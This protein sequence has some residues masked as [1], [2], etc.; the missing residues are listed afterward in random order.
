MSQLKVNAI[1]NTSATSDSITLASDGTATAKIT[2]NLSNRNLIINGAM[3]FAQRGTSSTAQ[4]LK[5][6]DRWQYGGGGLD[7]NPTQ[8]Q[9]ALTSSDT[10]PWE[11]GFR[12]S[13]HITN[14]NQSSGAGSADYLDVQHR[15]EAQ[16]IAQSGWDYTSASSYITLSFWI[17]SSVAQNFYGYLRSR[18]GTNQRYGFETGSLSADTWT[19]ITKTIPGNS[20]IQFDNDNGEGLRIA[21]TAFLGGDYT[22]SGTNLNTWEEYSSSTVTPDQTSTWYTTNDSTL[23][24]TGFQLEVG[25]YASSYEF[26]SYGDELAR[27]QRYYFRKGGTQWSHAL[28]GIMSSTTQCRGYIQFPVTMRA[29]PTMSGSGMY[30]DS[31]TTSSQDVTA[32]IDTHVLKDGGQIRMTTNTAG[33][34]AGTPVN[35]G[36]NAT[37]A[38]LAADAEL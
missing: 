10:G 7:E 6:V 37:T 30:V 11:K 5:T 23:E 14:G 20:N 1:R 21:F 13:Y 3:Q 24:F 19:K 2:N 12:Y 36:L 29:V 16:N 22:A 26:R 18:D 35:V 32:F 31:E 17:K 33:F 9:H 4:G 28:V 15:I 25:D 27:C 34:G 38:Y 8:A